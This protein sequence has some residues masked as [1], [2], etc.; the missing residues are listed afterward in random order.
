MVS[1]AQG[2]E[3][4]PGTETGDHSE[5]HRLEVMNE[6]GAGLLPLF[7]AG[8]CIFSEFLTLPN[9]HFPYQQSGD[10]DDSTCFRGCCEE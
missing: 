4:R 6:V 7:L 8:L 2:P 9:T 5:A 10:N 1:L 3:L